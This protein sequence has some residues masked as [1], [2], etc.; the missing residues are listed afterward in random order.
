MEDF[1]DFNFEGGVYSGK[2]YLKKAKE[3]TRCNDQIK[4]LAE[5]ADKTG[6][7]MLIIFFCICLID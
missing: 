7:T 1:E 6:P 3:Q 2:E 5:L 4:D